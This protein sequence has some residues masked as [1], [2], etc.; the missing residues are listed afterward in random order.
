VGESF[1]IISIG[2]IS[3][4]KNYEALCKAIG[5]LARTKEIAG[6]QLEIYGD[7]ALP[8]DISY[9][10]NLRALVREENISA[11]IFLRRG[12]RYNEVP[13][14]LHSADLFVNVSTTGSMDKAVLEA[15]ASGT[16]VLT[17][18]EAFK[19]SLSL[20][21]PLLFEGSNRPEGLAEKIAALAALPMGERERLAAAL[22]KW[23]EKEHDLAELARR[24]VEEFST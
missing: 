17:S 20:I 7:P 6:L 14:L 9:L 11:T 12:V 18:N 23:V 4:S 1:K 10:G 22:R 13:V 5:V 2:R 19:K 8:S 21:S 3:E 24:V 15:A 16:L